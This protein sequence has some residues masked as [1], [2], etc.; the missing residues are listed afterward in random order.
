MTDI[1][2]EVGMCVRCWGKAF[3]AAYGIGSKTQA[4]EYE[5]IVA[6]CECT[7]WQRL[8]VANGFA[9]G[10]EA[11]LAE[12]EATIED[13]TQKYHAAQPAPAVVM[14]PELEHVL[15]SLRDV[16]NHYGIVGYIGKERVEKIISDIAAVRAQAAEAGIKLPKV[17]QL[18]SNLQYGHSISG[19]YKTEIA[20]AL[21]EL[22]A[23]EGRK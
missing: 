3:T 8:G 2:Q 7:P 4:G 14:S 11:R 10:Y 16:C 23:A 13:I 19:Q 9:E 15:Q 12:R 5:R 20:T 6:G 1:Q 18:L 22:D 17:R 21:A